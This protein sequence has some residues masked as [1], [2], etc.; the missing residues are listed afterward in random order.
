MYRPGSTRMVPA[1]DEGSAASALRVRI[2]STFQVYGQRVG[3]YGFPATEK[4]LFGVWRERSSEA[5]KR[6]F[7]DRTGP[8]ISH[9][10]RAT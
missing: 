5:R 4:E 6:R 1:S 2:S 8:F 9:Q 7:Q 10:S 3:T